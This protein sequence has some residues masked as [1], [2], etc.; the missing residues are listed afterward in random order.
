VGP[1]IIRVRIYPHIAAGIF[2]H[3]AA[4]RVGRPP[5]GSRR[6]HRTTASGSA[7]S[8]QRG[9]RNDGNAGNHKFG[10]H[11]PDP[12]SRLETI[13]TQ[14]GRPCVGSSRT[15]SHRGG[16]VGTGMPMLCRTVPGSLPRTLQRLPFAVVADARL[17]RR[18]PLTDSGNT[19]LGGSPPPGLLC[20]RPSAASCHRDRWRSAPRHFHA[21]VF[22]SRKSCGVPR[23]KAPRGRK[24]Q[25]NCRMVQSFRKACEGS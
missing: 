4:F 5:P 24:D 18:C 25:G 10:Q 3:V 19:G 17:R 8:H 23:A 7:G 16:D 15:C 13:P 22:I 20:C 9:C 6:R 2:G 14:I 12:L 21:L 11:A 1:G